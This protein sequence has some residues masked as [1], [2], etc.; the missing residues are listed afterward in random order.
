MAKIFPIILLIFVLT[1][2]GQ[3]S[4][5][6]HRRV[7]FGVPQ[8]NFKYPYGSVV[9]IHEHFV[10]SCSGILISHR[11]VLSAAHCFRDDPRPSIYQVGYG[12]T[13]IAEQTRVNVHGIN[14]CGTLDVAVIKLATAVT[15]SKNIVFFKPALW[16]MD[17]MMKAVKIKT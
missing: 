8:N 14:F 17:N 16:N 2:S 7:F 1:N 4:N 11:Q 10:L 13:K 5:S 6:T 3:S 15:P 12:S 9:T